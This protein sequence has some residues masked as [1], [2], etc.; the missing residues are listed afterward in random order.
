MTKSKRMSI[1]SGIIVVLAV[2][3]AT[4]CG[5]F[6]VGIISNTSGTQAT[7][8]GPGKPVAT[9]VAPTPSASAAIPQPTARPS[10]VTTV[11]VTPDGA[12]WYG[13]GLRVWPAAGGGGVKRRFG[14]AVTHFGF[15]DGLP[16]ERV[17]LLKVAPDGVLWAG[18]GRYLA[19]F[20]GRAW[21]VIQPVARY[22]DSAV[23]DITFTPDGAVWIAS[24]FELVR[25]DG[26]S[27][28]MYGQMVH[29][30]AVA[31]DGAI[32]AAGWEGLQDSA[33]VG[34]FDGLD[35]T[36]HNT[37]EAFQERV[38]KMAITPDG[39]VWGATGRHG[40]VRFDGESW[41]EY[42]TAD[43][44][45]SNAIVDIGVAPDG[46]LWAVT[47]YG[48]AYFDGSA[49]AS[50]DDAPGWITAMAFA[51]DAT[52]WFGTSTG[53]VEN[54]EPK[55]DIYLAMT[56]PAPVGTEDAAQIQSF[57]V[58]PAQIDPGDV[59]TLTW[60]ALGDRA[61]ICP[62]AR[63]VLFAPDD[64][65]DVPLSG[66][67][68]FTVP[69]EAAGAQFIGFNL[70]V[71]SDDSPSPAAGWVST[72]LKCET[73][74]FFTDDPQA[75]ICPGEPIRSYG[76]AQRFER[77]TMLWIEELGR[78]VIL[79]EASLLG[80]EAR[81]TVSYVHDP[82]DILQDTS[83]QVHPPEGL[84]APVSGFG[85]VWRGDVRNS[86]GY[87]ESLGWALEPEFGYETVFQC[88]DALPSGGRSWQTCYLKGPN[89]EVIVLHPLG[90][91]HLLGEQESRVPQN[92]G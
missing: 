47:D 18:A 45:P 12:V 88:D 76:A 1:P 33:Y 3:L 86:A 36:T 22:I 11:A 79:E 37:I 64:C 14:G 8:T 50:V 5:T 46:L 69:H 39:L 70:T 38:A 16:D 62:S 34:R 2:L 83:A 26:R 84:Y 7:P 80:D 40:V 41:R 19:T 4:A 52:I 90:G 35:W 87:R 73:S 71:E 59:V 72:A 89:D 74:W 42:T 25:F 67:T 82:L 21:E 63:F 53:T 68:T 49:W 91:W 32:W 43:G 77:G 6:E 28:T 15:D 24:P 9:P 92:D 55:P 10:E 60:E 65:W 78:Y 27:V 17:Q 30:L 56:P 75:G 81:K 20:N 58:A 44:L 66:T 31:P 57:E 85:L 23:V 48:V 13:F 29:A 61:T 54:Y 51:P